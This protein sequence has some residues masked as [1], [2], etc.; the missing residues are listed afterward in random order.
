[1]FP[2][3]WAELGG[4]PEPKDKPSDPVLNKFRGN[5][6]KTSFGGTQKVLLLV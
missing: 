4:D 5:T 6:K 1:M 2:K 3:K